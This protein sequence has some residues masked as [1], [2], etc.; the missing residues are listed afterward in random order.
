MEAQCWEFQ[1]P[2]LAATIRGHTLSVFRIQELWHTEKVVTSRTE[3]VTPSPITIPTK[4]ANH[5][6]SIGEMERE[7]NKKKA[8]HSH[9]CAAFS[10]H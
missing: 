4:T 6:T 5:T 8:V 9:E 2:R 10:L 3:K 1:I 7:K